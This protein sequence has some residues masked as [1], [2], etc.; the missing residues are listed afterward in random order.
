MSIVKHDGKTPR[1]TI[2]PKWILNE[3]YE[4]ECFLTLEIQLPKG[5]AIKK[6]KTLNYL[7]LTPYANADFVRVELYAKKKVSE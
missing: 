5:Y 7:N 3:S 6:G 2:K 4:D 1:P